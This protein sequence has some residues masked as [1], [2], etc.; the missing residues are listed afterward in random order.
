MINIS[1]ESRLALKK[2]L[3]VSSPTFE[4]LNSGSCL[5]LLEKT[6]IQSKEYKGLLNSI[7][8]LFKR[9]NA[10]KV[11]EIELILGLDFGTSS[12]KII[13]RDRDLDSSTP[14]E[15]NFKSNP[16][17]V[18]TSVKLNG[19]GV[20]FID[21]VSSAKSLKIDFM[22]LNSLEDDRELSCKVV[23]F[24]ATVLRHS[25]SWFLKRNNEIY[26][27]SD[28]FWKVNMGA[29][30]GLM[31]VEEKSKI[32]E[33]AINK[34]WLLSKKTYKDINKHEYVHN[35]LFSENNEQMNE[36]SL[37]IS[38]EIAAL[39]L[40][41]V[42]ARRLDPDK[43]L[44]L[45]IDVGS[46]TLDTCLINI[47]AIERRF[48]FWAALISNK[49]AGYLH[50]TRVK[51]I[52]RDIKETGLGEET[53]DLFEELQQELNS[54][55]LFS[56]IPE[57]V[58]EYVSN[59][60]FSEES[61]AKGR[62]ESFSRDV[63]SQLDR[64][65]LEDGENITGVGKKGMIAILHDIAPLNISDYRDRIETI[66]CGG[67]SNCEF[68][69]GI[70]NEFKRPVLHLN[71][72]NIPPDLKIKKDKEN[73]MLLMNVSYGLSFGED[74]K[75]SFSSQLSEIKLKKSNWEDNF[76]EHLGK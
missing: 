2:K 1:P 65:Y 32:Y 12:T 69:R 61:K 43:P 63:K 15:F 23:S 35:F 36:V 57:K 3:L 75:V 31:E 28:I 52:I 33:E 49:G 34:A 13:I 48:S 24:L 38:P 22:K 7:T 21:S 67:G 73:C 26:K 53:Q 20:F 64:E 66:L 29:P 25:R 19:E 59:S 51:G 8:K 9:K 16:Y 56:E 42:K 62:E 40:G 44:L 55:F 27:E 54:G 58:T 46:S 60:L 71:E 68:Y 72:I 11:E 50:Q 4:E 74:W 17:L 5:N 10:T 30:I 41:Y 39:S 14:V 76:R 18:S 6:Q 47:D 37:M 70:I 45:L